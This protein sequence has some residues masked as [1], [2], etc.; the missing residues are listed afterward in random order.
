VSGCGTKE[1]DFFYS[2][3]RTAMDGFNV[4]PYYLNKLKIALLYSPGDR[5]PLVP[6]AATLISLLL[7]P[8]L[9]TPI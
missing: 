1:I 8:P 7:D 2:F 5:N 4:V 6:I 3:P 9:P